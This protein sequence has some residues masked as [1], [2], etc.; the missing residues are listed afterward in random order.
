MVWLLTASEHSSDNPTLE[1]GFCDFLRLFSEAVGARLL[2]HFLERGMNL[3]DDVLEFV[4]FLGR[5]LSRQKRDSHVA[6]QFVGN[7]H[8]STDSLEI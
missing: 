6:T 5:L 7:S 8:S 1:T 2:G 3:K 4:K